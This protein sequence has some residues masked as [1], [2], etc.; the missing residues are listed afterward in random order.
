MSRYPCAFRDDRNSCVALGSQKTAS[1]LCAR[2]GYGALR[3][4]AM[5]MRSHAIFLK[6]RCLGRYK[7]GNEKT[8]NIYF[9]DLISYY[10]IVREYVQFAPD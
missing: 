5:G 9:K 10:E 2:W 7:S 8:C 4:S 6:P 3:C 1:P